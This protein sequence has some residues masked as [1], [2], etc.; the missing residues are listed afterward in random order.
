LDHRRLDI[1]TDGRCLLGWRLGGWSLGLRRISLRRRLYRGRGRG[2]IDDAAPKEGCEGIEG[3]TH[4]VS[5]LEGTNAY[6][7]RV[8]A[9]T[10]GF[11][12]LVGGKSF[13]R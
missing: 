11:C 2:L 10:A 12:R 3:E 9:G 4:R 13:Q 8:T 5:S 1:D 6:S 7:G